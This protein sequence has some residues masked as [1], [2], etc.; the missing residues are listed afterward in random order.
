MAARLCEATGLV[1]EQRAEGL[2]LTDTSGQLTHVAMPAE[3]TDAHAPL[4]V[5]EHL[6]YRQRE[7]DVNPSLF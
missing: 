1:A 5:A 7:S 4:L 6:A 2:A 3:G